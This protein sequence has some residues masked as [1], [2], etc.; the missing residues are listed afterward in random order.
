MVVRI[1]TDGA[2]GRRLACEAALLTRLQP[3]LSVRVPGPVHWWEPRDAV[4]FGM[5]T[6]PALA[7]S[8]PSLRDF[9][10]AASTWSSDMGQFL[11]ELKA[12]ATAPRLQDIRRRTHWLRDRLDTARRMGPEIRKQLTALERYR[13]AHWFRV[14]PGELEQAASP[15]SLIHGDLWWENFLLTETGQLAGI[16]DGEWHGW[17]DP[18]IDLSALREAG[19]KVVDAVLPHYLLAHPGPEPEARWRATM[20]WGLRPLDSLEQA[21]RRNDKQEW[22]DG[23]AKL[24]AGPLLS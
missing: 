8:T 18:A 1:P 5:M 7:G 13:W 4:P 3:S 15:V 16:L 20:L 11:C 22:D 12:A 21:L 6:Y 24:R 9:I 10:G 14:V 19:E 23:I 2:A 17:D